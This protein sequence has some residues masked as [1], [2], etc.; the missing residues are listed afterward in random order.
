MKNLIIIGAR[1]FGREVYNWA[2]QCDTYKKEWTIKGFLDDDSKALDGFAG[3]DLPVISSVEDYKIQ[4]NDVF[5]CALGDVQERKK[6][7]TM[8]LDKGGEFINLIRPMVI[9]NSLN[10]KLGKGIIISSFCG[11]GNDSTIGDFVIIQA[12]SALGHDIKIGNYTQV[13]AYTHI[14]GNCEIGDNV[15]LNPGSIILPKVKI[16]DN[17]TVGAGSVVLKNVESDVTVFGN[18]AKR[19]F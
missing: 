9:I 5:I 14:G 12:F 17:S 11:I 4:A 19:I 8:I 13:N 10:V 15:T 6:Y 7:A 1:G 16:G 3:Y 18:P 2:L